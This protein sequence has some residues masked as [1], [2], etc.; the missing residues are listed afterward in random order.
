LAEAPRP[1][2]QAGLLTGFV[3]GLPSFISECGI[4]GHSQQHAHEAFR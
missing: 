1:R 4:G 2:F 3:L